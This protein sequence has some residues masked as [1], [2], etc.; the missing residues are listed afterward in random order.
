MTKEGL[1]SLLKVCWVE[2]QQ[3]AQVLEAYLGR[4]HPDWRQQAS[5]ARADGVGGDGPMNWAEALEVL[6]LEE[7]VSKAEIKVAHKRLIA[8]L[9]P[10]H[11][12]STG[13]SIGGDMES[14]E[15]G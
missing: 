1:M 2:D 6:G 12:G 13:L 8:G 7:G 4:V 10:D 14:G 15:T 3:S 9:H 5:G 11:G